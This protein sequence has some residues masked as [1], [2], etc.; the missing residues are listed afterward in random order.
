MR[1]SIGHK[2]DL[3]CTDYAAS[4]GGQMGMMKNLSSRLAQYN[5]SV[6]EVS[7]AMVGATGLLPSADSVPGVVDSI[8]LK[9]L[10]SPE[11][12]AN[13]VIM[14]T[15]TGFATVCGLMIMRRVE[16]TSV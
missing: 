8:P 16:L 1:G 11:E 2:A 13:V 9:R 5:I 15:K 7:P 6:N 10:C 12:V 4:K 14:Y 3:L